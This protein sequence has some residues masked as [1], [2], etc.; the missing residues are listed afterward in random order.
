[1]DAPSA[2]E[3]ELM[4]ARDDCRT[5]RDR[6]I[7]FEVLAEQLSRDLLYARADLTELRCRLL[8]REWHRKHG[9]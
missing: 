5:W 7:A 8:V 1:M 4:R 6:A 2:M 3:L 9:A